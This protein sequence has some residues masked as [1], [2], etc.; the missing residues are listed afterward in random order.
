MVVVIVEESGQETEVVFWGCKVFGGGCEGM[1][2]PQLSGTWREEDG[3]KKTGFG[4]GFGGD[5]VHSPG[6]WEEENRLK[7]LEGK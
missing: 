1:A 2:F 5:Q 3:R 7:L 4:S 6:T